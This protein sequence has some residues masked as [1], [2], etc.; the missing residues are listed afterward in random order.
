MMKTKNLILVLTLML[1]ASFAS[2]SAQEGRSREQGNRPDPKEM[3]EKI[4]TMRSE[5]LKKELKLTD[6]EFK[7]FIPLYNEYADKKF[8]LGSKAREVGH[9]LRDKENRTEENLWKVID[10]DL[11]N[12]I[13]E[14]QLQ[15]EY[16]YKFKVVLPAEKLINLKRAEIKFMEEAV[17]NFR[18]QEGKD[19]NRSD[20]GENGRKREYRGPNRPQ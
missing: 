11:D 2:V 15:K 18:R 19:R 16:F 8:E 1:S 3:K 5:F 12:Q 20:S 17:A 9:K 6:V 7:A 10:S 4:Q 14:A 13:K